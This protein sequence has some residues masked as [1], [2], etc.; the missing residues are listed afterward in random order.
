VVLAS[1]KFGNNSEVCEDKSISNGV[2]THLEV[3][4]RQFLSSQRDRWSKMMTKFNK[5]QAEGWIERIWT[6]SRKCQ[7]CESSDW[8]LL[9]NVWELREYQGGG[10]VV[11][12]GSVLPVVAMMCNVCGHTL[13]FN[14]IA[15]RVIEKPETREEQDEE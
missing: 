10:L 7:I 11:G 1:F 14:A 9:H 5:A 8:I 4:V 3:V 6:G 13:F 2:L 12:G 15:I